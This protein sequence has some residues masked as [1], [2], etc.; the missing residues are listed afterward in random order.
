MDRA[1]TQTSALPPARTDL[2]AALKDLDEGGLAI[3]SNA[4]SPAEIDEARTTVLSLAASELVEGGAVLA[5]GTQRVFGLIQKAP[6]FRRI[7]VNPQALALAHHI[8]GP[9]MM[10]YSMQAHIVPPGG[11][12]YPHFDQS[13]HKPMPPFPVVAAVVV[14]LEDFTVENGATLIGVGRFAQSLEDPAP[15]VEEMKPLTG[16][17]GTMS[18]YGGL[19]WHSTGVN[20]TTTPRVGILL[21][22]CMPWI[23]QHENYQRTISAAVA[24]DMTPQ[25]RDLLGI[26]EHLFGRRWHATA[27]E[28]T[29][30]SMS[31]GE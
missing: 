5:N 9:R 24:R 23:R 10:L 26:H 17:K 27:P 22:Y 28:F 3:V 20:H 11:R 16:A 7:A 31:H 2:D 13:D 4:F 21:H 6:I 25:M 12:M 30:R 19:L 8:L 18:A 14:M 1:L 15:P 29:E